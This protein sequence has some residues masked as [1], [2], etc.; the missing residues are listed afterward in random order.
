[1][2]GRKIGILGGSFDPIHLA[3][4]QLAKAAYEQFKLDSVIFLP[5]GNHSHNPKKTIAPPY[6]RLE[7][8]KLS[9]QD[10]PYFQV[11]EYELEKRGDS[12][13]AETL[14]YFTQIY[15]EYQ[16]YYIIG[17]DT[18]FKMDSW[19][20]PERCMK[21]AI[22]LVGNRMGHS[23]EEINQ[24]ISKIT[25]AYGGQIE[26]IE[27]KGMEIS[28]TMIRDL[29][30]N[31]KDASPYLK[32]LVSEYIQEN[33]LYHKGMTE[34]LTM[35]VKRRM[36]AGRFLHTLG[37]VEVAQSLAVKYGVDVE[38][39][40]IAALLH[41][42][43]KSL[44]VEESIEICNNTEDP[45]TEEELLSPKVLH[46]KVGAVIAQKEFHIEDLEI[47]NA[48]RYHTTGRPNMTTLEKIIFIADFIEPGRT[49]APNLDKIRKES[50]IDLNRC[51]F[52]IIRDTLQYLKDCGSHIDER[53]EETYQYYKAITNMN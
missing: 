12:Y 8:I 34:N 35:A 39:A 11:S 4:I 26:L 3:H 50:M 6:R 41:D 31:E 48:I 40:K 15:P 46:A 17:A 30:A 42:V 22:F 19:Y 21:K 25:G 27:M 7:M 24:Q 20:Y 53:S 28:S 38:R 47:L 51:V 36:S 37:V 49:K 29:L 45:I 1:M 16:F 5:S 43:A 14:D 9:I 18:L 44:S 23:L 13:T 2:L 32:P 33:H 52:M 10:Y